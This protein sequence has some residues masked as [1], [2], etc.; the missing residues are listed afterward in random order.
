MDETQEMLK[1]IL[2]R[3]EAESAANEGFRKEVR[4]ALDEIRDSQKYLAGKIGETDYELRLIKRK[5]G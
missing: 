5:Q 4:E 1:A 3:V 2:A